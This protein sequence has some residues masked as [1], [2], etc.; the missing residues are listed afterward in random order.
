VK[1]PDWLAWF[2]LDEEIMSLILAGRGFLQFVQRDGCVRL[3]VKNN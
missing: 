3:F 1:V 2:V